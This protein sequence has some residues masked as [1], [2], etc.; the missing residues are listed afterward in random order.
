MKADENMGIFILLFLNMFWIIDKR[1]QRVF[2]DRF[3][4]QSLAIF[5]TGVALKKS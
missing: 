1:N 3:D 2:H 4:Y 5:Q